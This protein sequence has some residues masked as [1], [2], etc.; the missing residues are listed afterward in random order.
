MKLKIILT[1]V[2]ILILIVGFIYAVPFVG[3]L[4]DQDQNHQ[5]VFNKLMDYKMREDGSIC[6]S[7]GVVM[8]CGA[9]ECDKCRYKRTNPSYKM[10]QE[11]TEKLKHDVRIRE[12]GL[13]CWGCGMIMESGGHEC[14][15]C[16]IERKKLT[17]EHL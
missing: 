11:E 17:G 5:E 14:N 10:T 12:K 3:K 9:G 13:I 16:L 8:L 7:C 15:D 4:T 1:I 6:Y 2:G